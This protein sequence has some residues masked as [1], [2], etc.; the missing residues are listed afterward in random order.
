VHVV[1]VENYH[2]G[3]NTHSVTDEQLEKMAAKYAVKLI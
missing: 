2:G 1:T 3:K